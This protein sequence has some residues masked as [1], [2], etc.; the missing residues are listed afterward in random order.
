MRYPTS[1]LRAFPDDRDAVVVLAIRTLGVL[2]VGLVAIALLGVVA[3]VDAFTGPEGGWEGLIVGAAIAVGGGALLIGVALGTVAHVAGKRYRDGQ[4]VGFLVPVGVVMALAGAAAWL[5]WAMSEH[6][7]PLDQYI[8]VLGT[9]VGLL[10][11]AL[12]WRISRS[13]SRQA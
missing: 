7:A 3:I 13:Q 1:W 8:A 12:A 9:V 4:D 2:S 5:P 6:R 10:G 11:I